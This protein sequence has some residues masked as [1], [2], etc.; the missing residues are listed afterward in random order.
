MSVKLTLEQT[1]SILKTNKE[2]SEWHVLLVDMLP[3]YDVDTVPRIAGFMA[4]CAHESADFTLLEEN[5][6]YSESAL[7]RVFPRYFGPGK[8]NAAE[9]ARNPEK[10]ANYVYMDEFRSKSGALGNTQ[11]GDGWRFRGGG[12]KQLTG[13]NNYTVFAKGIGKTPEEAA[14][15]VRTKQGALE[16]ACWFWSSN[17]LNAFA[18]ARDIVGMSKRINGGDI[19]LADRT[20]RWNAALK[21]LNSD[22]S[23][24][25]QPASMPT[26]ILRKGSRGPEVQR[27]Q[28]ALKIGADGIFGPGTETALKSWQKTNGLPADGIAGP[29]TFRILYA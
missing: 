7:L 26:T 16:S 8:R 21:I 11:S 25:V 27:L 28:Q 17:K 29:A 5:L 18:D 6:N 13:R 14:D 24:T 22:T 3:R 4:Q 19:G 23:T 20:A 15:Y 2:T 12:I 9:Y 10:L 1:R